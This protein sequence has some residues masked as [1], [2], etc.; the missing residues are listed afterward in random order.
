M[1]LLQAIFSVLGGGT[2]GWALT[3]LVKLAP[4]IPINEGMKGKLRA[5]AALMSSLSVVVIGVADG[6]L[7]I[8]SAQGLLAAVVQFSAAWGLSHLIHK[9][10]QVPETPAGA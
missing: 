5:T 4:F 1:Q 10:N 6:S 7:D 3:E 8:S 9:M 2:G